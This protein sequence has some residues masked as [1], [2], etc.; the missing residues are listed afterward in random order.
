MQAQASSRSWSR[1]KS[2]D[3]RKDVAFEE[4]K[5]VIRGNT[6]AKAKSESESRIPQQAAELKMQLELQAAREE[7][8]AEAKAE[9]RA[10][11]QRLQMAER[12][13]RQD[14]HK[15]KAETHAAMNAVESALAHNSGDHA[16][17]LASAVREVVATRAALKVYSSRLMTLDWSTA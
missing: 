11:I 1:D 16:E 2:K 14:L 15:A 3:K 13:M 17:S 9:M 4:V 7:G 8:A 12:E 10:E 6:P 5:A